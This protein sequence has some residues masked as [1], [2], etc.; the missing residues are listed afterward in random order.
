MGSPLVDQVVLAGQDEKRLGAIAVLNPQEPLHRQIIAV[1][2]AE[3]IQALV[4]IINDPQ[5]TKDDY[6]KASSELDQFHRKV[7]SDISLMPVVTD[8]IK[9]SLKGFRQWEQVGVI[10]VV[11]EPFAMING[12]LTQ[13]YKVKRSAV[14]EKYWS[15]K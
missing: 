10:R 11:L 7:K 1:D 13:S 12:L 5:C 3:R 14:L 9:R 6:A 15:K 2:E 8:G 4:D